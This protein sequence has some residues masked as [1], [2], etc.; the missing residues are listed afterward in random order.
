[1][2]QRNKSII[3]KWVENARIYQIFPDRFARDANHGKGYNLE[4][5]TDKPTVHGFKGGNLRGLEKKLEYIANLG[6]NTLYITP[7][8]TSAANHRYHTVDYYTIDPLL[9]D[10]GDFKSFLE[11]AKV[12][13]FRIILDG[14]FNHTGRGF[15]GFNSL[16]ESGEA[17]P[18]R[19]WFR[20]HSFPVYPYE[21]NREPGYNCWMGLRELPQLNVDNPDVREYLFKIAEHWVE[22]GIDG[23]RLDAAEQIE[24]HDFWKELRRRIKAIRSDVLIIGEIWENPVPWLRGD[25][26]DGVMN[27]PVLK[28]I[29]ELLMPNDSPH[30][31]YGPYSLSPITQDEFVKNL[32]Q[33]FSDLSSDAITASMNL[34]GS[35]DTPRIFTMLDCNPDLVKMA[36]FFLYSLPG[37]PCLYYGDELLMEGSYDPDCRRTMPWKQ[38]EQNGVELEIILKEL[39]GLREHSVYSRGT[40]HF[41]CPEKGIILLKREEQGESGGCLINISSTP[42]K[43]TNPWKDQSRGN[44]ISSIDGVRSEIV[45]Q[46]R[47]QPLEALIF[48][49]RCEL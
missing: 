11:E 18:Y 15:Y 46:I 33:H 9:G 40:V 7:I 20:V 37:I 42:L 1:M 12:Q 31:H 10:M 25:E 43:I 17:S 5:W 32:N 39:S 23:W 8:F 24:D 22:I 27:Y 30:Y 35:H 21:E 36:V 19:N 13:N 41:S 3:P 34:L 47:L 45:D 6:F 38:I 4:S 14:V 48:D 16:V 28:N 26:F 49:P 44:A 29:L 2:K